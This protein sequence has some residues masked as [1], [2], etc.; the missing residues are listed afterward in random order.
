MKQNLSVSI[1]TIL[2]LASPVIS[3]AQIYVTAQVGGVPSV[4]GATLETFDEPS[5]AILTLSANAYLITGFSTGTPPYFS[6]STAAYFG[7]SPSTG[8]DTTPYVDIAAG[9][10]ATLNFSTPQNY[11]GMVIGTIDANNRLTFY[12]SANNVIGTVLGSQI[13]NITLGSGLPSDT[14]Y[15]NITSTTPFSKV[16]GD[17]VGDDFEFDDVAYAL[18]VPEPA[19]LSLLAIG[20]LGMAIWRRSQS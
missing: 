13:P 4:S 18:V 5:P 16:V 1:A 8:F 3:N 19:N 9:G 20:I 15:V 6:G 17:N 12:D 10:S 11:L 7:E 14:A 2:A